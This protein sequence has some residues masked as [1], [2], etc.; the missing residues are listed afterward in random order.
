VTE[1]GK[2]PGGGPL[3]AIHWLPLARK[4]T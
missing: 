3:A 1:P 2:V 4:T